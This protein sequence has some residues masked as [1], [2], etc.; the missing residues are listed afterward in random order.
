ME[1]IYFTLV[2]I[3]LYLASDW[4][5]NQIEARRGKRFENRSLIF[6]VIILILS[7]LVFS[8][9]QQQFK[10]AANSAVTS[11]TGQTEPGPGNA[12]Q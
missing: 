7:I 10:P 6:F 3:L 1:I 11:E 2:A 8:L 12:R 9:L 5:L 4:I